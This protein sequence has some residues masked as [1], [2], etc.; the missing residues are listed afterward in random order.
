MPAGEQAGANSVFCRDGQYV[1]SFPFDQVCEICR[2]ISGGGSLP[3]LTL[4][5]ISRLKPRLQILCSFVSAI[6]LR[7]GFCQGGIVG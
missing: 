3:I 5:A 4:M 7:A 2:E 6:I 1:K